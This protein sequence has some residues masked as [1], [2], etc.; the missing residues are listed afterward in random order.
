M[1]NPTADRPRHVVVVGAQCPAEGRLDNLE[2]AARDLHSVLVDPMLGNCLPCDGVEASLLLGDDLAPDQVR[3][4]VTC[5]ARR[6]ARDGGVL[7]VALLG[8]GFAGPHLHLMVGKSARADPTSA[9]DVPALLGAVANI[10]GVDGVIALVDTCHAGGAAPQA[11][12]LAGG[13]RDGRTRLAVVTAAAA[14]Q[15]ARRMRFS[16]AVAEV[17]RAGVDSDRETLRV[18]E[19]FVAAVRERVSGQ[20]VGY[21]VH[22]QDAYAQRPLWLA[23][24]VRAAGVGGRAYGPLAVRLLNEAAGNGPG[25]PTRWTRTSLVA[26]VAQWGDPA[27][28]GSVRQMTGE[29]LAELLE[30][31]DECALAATLLNGPLSDLLSESRLRGAARLAG[32]PPAVADAPVLRDLLEHAVLR[33][34]KQDAAPWHALAG[35]VAA[36]AH[37]GEVSLDDQALLQWARRLGVVATVRTALEE[38]AQARKATGVRLVVGLDDSW[39]GWPPE[40][41]AW[42][43]RQ[44]TTVGS[45]VIACASQDARGVGAA[46]GSALQWA[47]ELLHT[48]ERP[49]QHVDVA[50]SAGIL[51]RWHPEE[52]V[53]GRR[54]LGVGYQVVARWSGPLYPDRAAGD[55]PGEINDTSAGVIARLEGRPGQ[56]ALG[57]VDHTRLED[58]RELENDLMTRPVEAAL[59]LDRRTG[60]WARTLDVLLPYAPVLLWPSQDATL[61]AEQ[62]REAVAR[63]WHTLPDGFAD[64]HRQRLGRTGGPLT[65]LGDVRA[66]WHDRQWLGFCRQFEH[67]VVTIPQQ[68]AS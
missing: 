12:V 48:D 23:N 14:D 68:E 59:G 64:A 38:Y 16:R 41:Q 43:I 34:Q 45:T 57:W 33:A 20:A 46:I 56:D 35:F 50:A 51:A 37:L 19:L 18:D 58:L 2:T 62:L 8:H 28:A 42:L 32:Y 67:R 13:A 10:A 53:A 47:R 40:I 7:V 31:L 61:S 3:D 66:V 30:C 27:G 9:V 15:N 11:A 39:G 36:L 52:A 60:D 4:A 63:H 54:L 6:A 65:E 25:T 49:L 26:A 1:R 17:I 29:R 24:N 5:A 55:D 22:D 21:S 44:G